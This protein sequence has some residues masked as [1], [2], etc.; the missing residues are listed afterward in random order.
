MTRRVV[1]QELNGV[2]NIEEVQIHESLSQGIDLTPTPTIRE[3]EPVARLSYIRY[4]EPV[5]VEIPKKKK[6]KKVNIQQSVRKIAGF[7]GWR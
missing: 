5:K 7:A 2:I 1:V 3:V 4:A 6:S